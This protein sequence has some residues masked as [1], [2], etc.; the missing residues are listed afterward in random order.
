M[1]ALSNAFH[2]SVR[3]QLERLARTQSDAVSAAAAACFDALQSDHV[4]HT[5]GTGHSA[6]GAMEMF[7]RAGGLVPVNG[8]LQSELSPFVPPVQAAQRERTAGLADDLLDRYDVRSG[9]VVIVFSNSGIN[10]APIELALGARTRGATTI[11]VTNV[12]HSNSVDSRHPTKTRLLDHADH[13]LD[14]CGI[15]GDAVV[16]VDPDDPQTA[17]IAPTSTIAAAYLANWI[18]AE[19][20]SR[21]TA[22]GL[23]A[24][25]YKSANLPG[26]DEHN[27]A[28]EA[29]Y[30][31]RI[32]GLHPK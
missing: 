4:L 28:L 24:P 19:V 21:Y 14:T 32:K 17:R 8:I 7:H 9:D 27:R 31:D 2:D 11:A 3:D 10:A 29:R 13:V 12:A 16:A 26:G 23:D 6:T 18:V 1:S 5:F 15:A 22:A 30:A 20:V 25:I